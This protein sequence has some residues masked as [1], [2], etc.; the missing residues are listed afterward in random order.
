MN[1][2]IRNTQSPDKLTPDQPTLP[3]DAASS[4]SP[5]YLKNLTPEQSQKVKEILNHPTGG[6][7]EKKSSN[8]WAIFWLIALT[9]VGWY[10]VVRKT[11]WPSWVK[12]VV[13]IVTLLLFIGLAIETELIANQ[14]V[15]TI[16]NI[17]TSLLQ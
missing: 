5:N 13:V 2:P 7:E 10:F 8:G 11:T 14:I 15:G 16:G 6:Y 9:P 12:V 3:Y 1:L 17:D 4:E